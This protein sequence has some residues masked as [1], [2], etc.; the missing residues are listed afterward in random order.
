[1]GFFASAYAIEPRNGSSENWPQG[2]ARV[3]ASF[4]IS[5]VSLSFDA[6][7]V[8]FG[9]F[10]RKEVIN[11]RLK[12]MKVRASPR[13]TPKKA[14]KSILSAKRQKVKPSPAKKSISFSQ[15]Q[16][17]SVS[18]DFL[19]APVSNRSDSSSDGQPSPR[20]NTRSDLSISQKAPKKNDKTQA[21]RVSTSN[22]SVR[23]SPRSPD[24]PKNRRK[25][26]RPKKRTDLAS[27]EIIRLQSTVHDLI[28]R[29][30]FQR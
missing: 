16:D 6:L 27:K 17:S 30:P 21:S 2:G 1:M 11:N 7:V 8:A 15:D 10:G 12:T 4:Q 23:N 14:L 18:Y 5:T 29:L 20:R 24:K 22:A 13:N 28:P 3:A 19:T 25:Q 26:Q 9:T